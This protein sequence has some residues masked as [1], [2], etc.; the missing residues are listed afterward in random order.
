MSGTTGR[1]R[2]TRW[3]DRTGGVWTGI[4]KNTSGG[5]EGRRLGHARFLDHRRWWRSDRACTGTA[6]WARRQFDDLVGRAARSAADLDV[7]WIT[8]GPG[9]IIC[10]VSVPR[11]GQGRRRRQIRLRHVSGIGELGPTMSGAV[12]DNRGKRALNFDGLSLQDGQG[13]SPRG[14]H[15]RQRQSWWTWK[16][17]VNEIFVQ[18][19]VRLKNNNIL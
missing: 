10:G 8:G 1:G 13:Y 4:R 9:T 6:L 12:P 15:G 11:S 16:R 2:R 14:S 3:G 17:M 5:H 19:C 7:S 18:T